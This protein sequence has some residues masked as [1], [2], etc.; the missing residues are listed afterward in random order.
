MKTFYSGI[1]TRFPAEE[2]AE[3]DIKGSSRHPLGDDRRSDYVV[4]SSNPNKN[5][6]NKAFR[7]RTILY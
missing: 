2:E 5:N 7:N 1:I 3:G 4:R 6:G